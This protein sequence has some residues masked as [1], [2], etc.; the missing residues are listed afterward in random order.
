MSDVI[1][2]LEQVAPEGPVGDWRDV[3]TRAG[4]QRSA[5]LRRR[6][7]VGA[8][9]LVLL[10]APAL[11]LAYRFTDVLVV[12]SESGEP[13]TAWIAGDRLHNL[14]EVEESRLAAP[15]NTYTSNN[16]LFLFNTSAAI[17]SVDKRSLLYR[18]IDPSGTPVLRLHEV[19]T[20]R[21]RILEQDAASFAWRGDGVLAYAKAASDRSAELGD[22]V[23]HVL[24][25]KSVDGPSVRWTTQ[26]ARYTVL[27]WAAERLLVAAIAAGDAAP[28]EGEGVYALAGPGDARK[29]PLGGVVAVDPS[30]KLAVGPVTLEPR[31]A[32]SLTFRV[33]RIRDGEVLAE[34]DLPPVVDPAQPYAAA[35]TATGGSWADSYIVVALASEGLSS[36]DALV[37]LRF[38]GEELRPAHVFRLEPSSATAAGLGPQ[39]QYVFHSPRFLDD[40]GSE[41][42]AWAGLTAREGERVSVSSVLLECNVDERRCQRTDPLPGT[43]YEIVGTTR[44]TTSPAPRAFVENPSRPLSG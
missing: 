10:A 2:R 16:P 42:V 40:A 37:V 25:R 36:T 17:A 33:V 3:V 39:P 32:G 20:G 11:S 13:A 14:G 43:R 27:A 19:E 21:D 22:P 44:A 1:E 18:A 12:S 15:L 6:V 23:G 26:S 4:R 7:L 9:T 28:A 8:V 30:G 5:R 38:N 31:L 41:I 35:H 24:V 34:L 29:L